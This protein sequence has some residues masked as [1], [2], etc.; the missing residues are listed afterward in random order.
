MANLNEV[1]NALPQAD[2][3]SSF[4][5][6]TQNTNDLKKQIRKS[7]FENLKYAKQICKYFKGINNYDT[8]LNIFNFLKTYVPYYIEPAK[9]QT[10]RTLPRMLQDAESGNGSDCKHYS[11]FTGT[12]LQAL[13]IPFKYRLAGYNTEYPQ[14]IYCIITNN[15]NPICVDAVFQFYNTEKK[16]TIK[17]DMALYNLSGIETQ[18]EINGRFKDKLKKI[19]DG[20]KTVG[21]AIPRGAMLGLIDLNVKSFATKLAKLYESKGDAGLQWW[22]QFGGNIEIL[23]KNIDKGK[24]RKPLFGIAGTQEAEQMG[25]VIPTALASAAPIIMKILDALKKAGINPEEIVEAAK[26]AADGFEALTGKK[27]TDVLFKKGL[28]GEEDKPSTTSLDSDSLKPINEA[29]ANKVLQAKA[30]AEVN[31]EIQ[32]EGKGNFFETHKKQILIGGGVLVGSA[33]LYKILK[34]K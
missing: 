26:E 24:K 16:P 21:L 20:V 14:H 25:F 23:K 8:G 7:H 30:K 4:I 22:H 17:Q 29:D 15:G 19:T 11:I 10:T 28:G 32:N 34:K 13:H 12:I 1:I 27:V 5:T 31:R 6:Q 18:A 2:N 9:K 3:Q 33:I